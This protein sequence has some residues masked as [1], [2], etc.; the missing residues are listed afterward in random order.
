MEINVIKQKTVVEQVME[1]IKELIASGEYRPNDKLPNEN[2]LANMFGIGRSSIREAIKIFQYLGIVESKTGKGTFVCDRANISAEALTWS[3]LLGE[4]DM[5]EMIELRAL[6]EQHGIKI[7]LHK[8]E[9]E[10]ESADETIAKLKKQILNMKDA[11]QRQSTMD[12]IRAD[13]DFHGAIIEGSRNSLFIAIYKILR[14]FMHEEIKRTYVNKDLFE[15]VSEHREFLNVI[16]TGDL[17]ET[18]NI[19]KN[20]IY[21]IKKKLKEQQSDSLMDIKA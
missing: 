6:L 8:K 20:H 2:E 14:S 13:Y 10:P 12:L 1:Q 21:S 5:F 3:M 17:E 18:L 11:A 16:Q 7:L 4:N 9:N 15:T 19:F